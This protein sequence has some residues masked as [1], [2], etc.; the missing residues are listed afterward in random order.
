M[1]Y[2]VGTVGAS[3]G[4]KAHLFPWDDDAAA[5]RL[6]TACAVDDRVGYLR[7]SDVRPEL[8]ARTPAEW[9]DFADANPESFGRDRLCRNC[10]RRAEDG[11]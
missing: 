9:L 4:G 2:V 1:K 5:A 8:G 6:E 7:R 3:G 11:D 10:L